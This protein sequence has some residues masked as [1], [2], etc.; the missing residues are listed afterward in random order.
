VPETEK[1]W[2]AATEQKTVRE[3]ERMVSGRKPGDRPEDQPDSRLE[4]HVLRFEVT[5]E[6]RS[7]FHDALAKLTGEAG[8]H[9]DDDTLL[10]L[11]ARQVLGGPTDEGRSSYQI[12]MTVCERCAAGTQTGKGEVNPVDGVVVEMARCDAQQILDTH[13]GGGSAKR[14]SQTIPPAVRRQVI[15]RHAGKC[16]VPGCRHAVFVDVHHLNPREENCGHDPENLI[17]LC[18]AHH[19][20]LHRGTLVV[21]GSF[22]TGLGFGHADGSTYGEVKAPSR[23][24]E[25]TKV[26]RALRGMGFRERQARGAVERAMAHVGVGAPVESLLQRALV[27]ISP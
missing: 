12:T 18:A 23:A 22:A 6:T 15:Q 11:M 10:L 9:L 16:C 1:E 5:A 2:L 21:S 4:R 26:F 8:Q 19:R 20:A 27:E 13:V 3:V 17:V 24:D 14:A 7:T 25:V